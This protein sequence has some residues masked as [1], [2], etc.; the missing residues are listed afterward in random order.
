LRPFNQENEGKDI[1]IPLTG[2]LYVPGKMTNNQTVLV[3]IGTGYY[4][5]KNIKQAQEYAERKIKM[6]TENAEKVSQAVAIKRKNLETVILFMQE[7]M[8]QQYEAQQLQQKTDV[9][10]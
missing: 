4:V 2:S 5:Q 6:I 1:L 3:D 9:K 10:A 8:Q 7:Q